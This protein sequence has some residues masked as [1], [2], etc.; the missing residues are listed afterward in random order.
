MTRTVDD[1]LLDVHHRRERL[2]VQMEAAELDLARTFAIAQQVHGRSAGDI[3]RLLGP[4]VTP[5]QVG[6]QIRVGRRLLQTRTR[7]A[8]HTE[9][10]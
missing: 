7:Q 6:Y 4:S 5:D 2:K 8:T 9:A 10:P 1:V 3:S